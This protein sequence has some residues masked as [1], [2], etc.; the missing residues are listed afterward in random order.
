VNPVLGFFKRAVLNPLGDAL[1][2]DQPGYVF[3]RAYLQGAREAHRE[4]RARG[5]SVVTDETAD[6]NRRDAKDDRENDD[7]GT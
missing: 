6:T 3:E 5:E 1:L 4:L 2:G 7:G